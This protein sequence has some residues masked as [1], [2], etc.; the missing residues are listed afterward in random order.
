[1]ERESD[2]GRP[3]LATGEAPQAV[4]VPA[5]PEVA[6]SGD[7]SNGTDPKQPSGAEVEVL[8]QAPQ[9]D[10]EPAPKPPLRLNLRRGLTWAHVETKNEDLGASRI[11]DLLSEQLRQVGLLIVVDSLNTRTP[12][13]SRIG[14][15]GSS[16][17]KSLWDSPESILSRAEDQLAWAYWELDALRVAVEAEQLDR[18][19]AIRC[20]QN[21]LAILEKN[22]A[23]IASLCRFQVSASEEELG[24]LVSLRDQALLE[25]DQDREDLDLIQLLL[26]SYEEQIPALQQRMDLMD[27]LAGVL[28]GFD[29]R[30]NALDATGTRELEGLSAFGSGTVRRQVPAT[31]KGLHG[32]VIGLIS[33]V[34]AL[35]P[36]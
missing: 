31:W 28:A 2:Q 24:R 27:A 6:R 19:E 25:L 18:A 11:R 10:L 36:E 8:S 21:L 30:V 5:T 35:Q 33:S 17:P 26:E 7:L 9:G 22:S 12:S 16:L 3:S 34:R 14:V 29:D 4:D 32:D 15:P 20:T 13:L 1:M 23:Q